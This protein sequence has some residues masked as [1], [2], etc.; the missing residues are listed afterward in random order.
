MKIY[1]CN[2]DGGEVRLCDDDWQTLRSQKLPA[3]SGR[4]SADLLT[5][6]DTLVDGNWSQLRAVAVVVGAGNF[7]PVR[8]ACVVANTLAEATGA[9]LFA[10]RA[11]SEERVRVARAEAVYL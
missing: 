7:T 6:L 8:I 2:L 1:F 3:G 11:G 10:V 5:E 4:Q 9:E